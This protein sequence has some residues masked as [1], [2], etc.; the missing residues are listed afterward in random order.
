MVDFDQEKWNE[1]FDKW[2]QLRYKV[3]P[4]HTRIHNSKWKVSLFDHEEFASQGIK[5][6]KGNGMIQALEKLT[7][8]CD[9]NSRTSIKRKQHADNLNNVLLLVGLAESAKRDTA[10]TST[11]VTHIGVGI[12]STAE[13][14]DQTGLITAQ[15]AR[16]PFDTDGDRVVTNQ[17][18]KY[19][20]YFDDT[21]ITYPITL[22]EACTFTAIT[23][24]IAH[25]RIQHP[26]FLFGVNDVLV[27][28]INETHRNG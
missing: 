22:R 18:A 11:S 2:F 19:H 5:K 14:E 1:E 23:A 27:Y 9:N 4:K 24:G 28:Q 17:T 3:P 10:E 12:G 25:C 15:D 8:E 16:K 6:G 13:N 7:I 20:M 21:D 26:D